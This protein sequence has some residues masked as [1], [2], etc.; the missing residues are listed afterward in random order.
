[1]L[2]VLLLVGVLALVELISRDIYQSARSEVIE[3]AKFRQE[4]LADQ[5]AHGIESSYQA[6]LSNLDFFR[7]A[8]SE[9]TT[10]Q[11]ADNGMGVQRN[12]DH[13]SEARQA[14][15]DRFAE[16]L[17]SQSISPRFN[18][19]R[20]R[21]G[22]RGG[23]IDTILWRQLQGR[24]SLLFGIDRGTLDRPSPPVR[25]I[26]NDDARITPKAVVEQSRAWLADVKQATISEFQMYDGIGANLVCVPFPHG[27]L[28]VAVVPIRI[29]EQKFLKDMNDDPHTGAWLIDERLTAMAASRPSLVGANMAEI[30][31]PSVRKLAVDF[32]LNGRSGT[33][34]IDRDFKIGSTSFQSSLVSAE[35]IRIGNKTWELFVATTTTEVDGIVSK[36]FHR[37]LLWGTIVVLVVT[38][39][40]VSTAIQLIRSRTR[41]ERVRHELLN[42]ELKQAR[43][44]QLAWLPELQ[45]VS[46]CVEVAAINTPASHISGD[47]YNWFDLD[48]GR[49]VVTI[50]DVTGHGMAAAFLMATTQ[51]LVR[52]SM[53][54]VNGN[55]AACLEDVNRQLCTQVFNGQ[56]VT[57]LI[58]VFD[59]EAGQLQLA[60]AGHP[61]PLISNGNGFHPL[62]IE[63]QLVLGIEL[64]TRYQNETLD[65]TGTRRLLFYTDGVVDCLTHGGHRFG[66]DGLL[67]SLKS[68]H[69]CAQDLLV[70]VTGAIEIFR[71]K[72]ELIDDLTLVAVQVESSRR[73]PQPIYS[74]AVGV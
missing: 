38:G 54:R 59:C 29:I 3:Q 1:M 13:A 66:A 27:R 21:G 18:S 43:Q 2:H 52:N 44:I 42:R 69:T 16:G 48:D 65:F 4:L 53:P 70:S 61:S 23:F 62:I 12:V 45:P 30:S 60:T 34:L 28:L 22:N 31:D 63:P 57:M 55:P 9:E 32:I 6:V 74:Q 36:L 15:N 40:L 50:G 58:A 10:T 71:H 49:T 56:F 17:T 46:P 72:H 7:R 26:G 11:P 73:A 8:E 68:P 35:P 24:V 25:V 67:E 5:T 47:F 51:L 33:R 39:L 41:L 64:D 19:S 37:A 14:R 20:S